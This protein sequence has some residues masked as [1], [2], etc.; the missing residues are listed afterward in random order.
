MANKFHHLAF[1]QLSLRQI[2]SMLHTKF[3]QARLPLVAGAH[4]VLEFPVE[5]ALAF[6]SYHRVSMTVPDLSKL[7]PP[8]PMQQSFAL[9]LPN[10]RGK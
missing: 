1:L 3:R 9:L 4:R 8:L 6:R 10:L 7:Q 5:K 2:N